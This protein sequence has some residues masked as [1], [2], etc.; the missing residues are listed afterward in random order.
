MNTAHDTTE[1]EETFQERVDRERAERAA[2]S[3]KTAADVA[4]AMNA[5]TGDRWSGI[6]DTESY[7]VHFQLLRLKD[8]ISLCLGLSTY[9]RPGHWHAYPGSITTE[10]GV[11]LWLSEH[12]RREDTL[13]A[14]ISK[15][16][17]PV[18]VARDLC[19][20]ILPI[21]EELARRALEARRLQHERDTW[22]DTTITR[23]VDALAPRLTFTTRQ[24]DKGSLRREL[25]HYGKPH[26]V[27]TLNACDHTADVKIEELTPD[28]ALAMLSQIPPA[29]QHKED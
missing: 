17:S 8:N 5:V 19:R 22:L 2:L 20:R 11:R 21:A 3:T 10:D 27:I 26:A 14:N 1:H 24:S 13:S 6:P 16:K 7:E 25:C 28:T 9:P 23:M 15:D 12:E 29:A 18:Q 4:R